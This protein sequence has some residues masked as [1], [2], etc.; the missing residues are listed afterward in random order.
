MYDDATCTTLTSSLGMTVVLTACIV[1]LLSIDGLGMTDGTG[2]AMSTVVVTVTVPSRLSRLMLDV[3]TVVS[4]IGAPLV[5]VTSV[6]SSPGL[7]SDSKNMPTTAMERC[8]WPTTCPAAIAVVVRPS[9]VAVTYSMMGVR[10]N[11]EHL[12]SLWS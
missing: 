12:E 5:L 11:D 2:V 6:P 7:T 9:A 10:R 1:S 3:A 8:L 4:T